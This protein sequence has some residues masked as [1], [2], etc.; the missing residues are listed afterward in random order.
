MLLEYEKELKTFFEA[1]IN[2]A[3]TDKNPMA[4]VNLKELAS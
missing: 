4:E 2:A 1:K 3:I